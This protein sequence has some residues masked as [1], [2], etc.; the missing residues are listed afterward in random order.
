MKRLRLARAL[1]AAVV[2][3]AMAGSVATAHA[4]IR[5]YEFQLVD[6]AVKAGPDRIITVRLI[7]KATGK[8]VPDAVIFATRL[9]MAPDGMQEMATKVTPVPGSEPGSYRSAQRC[10]A[11]PARLRTSSSSGPNNEARD[12]GCRCDRRLR[13][14]RRPDGLETR[15]LA[16]AA[17]QSRARR[18]AG[19]RGDHLLP[20]SRWPAILF[21]N[22]KEDPGWSRVPAGAEG[23]RCQFRPR[24]RSPSHGGRAEGTPGQILSQPDGTAR[25][26]RG[27]QE[28]F[29]GD[30][31]H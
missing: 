1:Q 25:H 26:F 2:G 24:G 28:R 11:K 13:G 16:A 19:N 4:D 22:A 20:T 27:T 31:L 15:G 6:Q 12:C 23:S 8:P 29:D 14:D 9:D 17:S 21:V 7:N 3:I 30:G 18:R 10:K 5:N